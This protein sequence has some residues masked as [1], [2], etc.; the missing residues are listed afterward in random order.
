MNLEKLNN[1]DN[2]QFLNTEEVAAA[3]GCSVPT[4][5][6][7]MHRKDFPLVRVGKSMKVSKQAF[8]KWAET[9][10]I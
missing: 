1:T 5:R 8:L 7:I 3:L 10:R 9:K 4:A 6:N 2:I